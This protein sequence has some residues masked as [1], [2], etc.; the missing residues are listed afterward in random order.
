MA[1]SGTTA[2]T[3]SFT[4]IAE[5]AFE[6]AGSELRTGYHLRTARRSMALLTLEWANRGINLWTVEEG[7]LSLVAATATYTL[8]TDTIDLLEGTLRLNHGVTASQTDTTIARVGFSVYSAIP[9]KL[10][11][12]RP[13][14]YFVDRR[15][16][17]PTVTFWPVPPDNSYRFVYWRLRR[18]QDPGQAVENPDVPFR[19]FPALVAGLAYYVA[20]KLPEPEARSRLNGLQAE[21]ERQ[22]ELAAQEDRQRVPLRIVPRIGRIG[23]P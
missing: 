14:Q 22:F 9:N 1:T 23:R 13:A 15:R 20:M 10:R 6:R 5:E 3:L 17:A 21:Y 2:F 8:P 7:V 18:M 19:F 12:A 16:D 4:D 11:Q